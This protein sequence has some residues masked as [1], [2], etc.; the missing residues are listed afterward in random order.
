MFSK[1]LSD[2]GKESLP[3]S[4]PYK[5]EP[6]VNTPT[7]PPSSFPSLKLAQTIHSYIKVD[8]SGSIY[9]DWKALVSACKLNENSSP[10]KLIKLCFVELSQ[11][12]KHV[13][14]IERERHR[15]KNM[16]CA[17]PLCQRTG[18]A[19]HMV[20]CIQCNMVSYCSKDC[21]TRDKAAH[22]N[23]CVGTHDFAVRQNILN[24]LADLDAWH[25]ELCTPKPYR[26]LPSSIEELE[27]MKANP[28]QYPVGKEKSNDE[29]LYLPLEGESETDGSIHWLPRM[30]L[31]L[32]EKPSMI[33]DLS[34]DDAFDLLKPRRNPHLCMLFALNVILQS[35][36]TINDSEKFSQFVVVSKGTPYM[37]CA[38]CLGPTKRKAELFLK[39]K[40]AQGVA[41]PSEGED[42][43]IS[44]SVIGATQDGSVF[45][46]VWITCSPTCAS[47]Y[48]EALMSRFSFVFIKDPCS[49]RVKLSAE[50]L[51]GIGLFA[52]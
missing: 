20:K 38:T 12:V 41:P 51:M 23:V 28:H 1:P 35:F 42:M 26:E 24:I 21:L 3:P 5:N 45:G 48:H 30:P 7:H 17:R 52:A 37:R 27:R 25:Q 16:G 6:R 34:L 15:P 8:K 47:L 49:G 40:S 39:G 50:A 33:S 13:P 19:E 29:K 22:T 9:L 36:N 2:V 14:A 4:S 11:L 18:K 46:N 44:G 10:V 43:L 32:S 31:I